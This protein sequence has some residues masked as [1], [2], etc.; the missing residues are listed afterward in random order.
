VVSDE[1]VSIAYAAGT[2]GYFLWVITL[3]KI[4]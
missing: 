1:A 3:T 4:G 2:G